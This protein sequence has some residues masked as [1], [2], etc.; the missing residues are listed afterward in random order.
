MIAGDYEL[1]CELQRPPSSRLTAS[2]PLN[3]YYRESEEGKQIMKSFR[4]NLTVQELI[5]GGSDA[6]WRLNRPPIY[7][8][9][10]GRHLTS[11]IW[12]DESGKVKS[13]VNV[14]LE[15]L[16]AANG[17][18]AQWTVHEITTWVDR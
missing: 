9:Q 8:I 6:K 4:E 1:A 14:G 15:Y 3:Q 12:E 11:T 10:S 18:V 16:P 2:M 5:D 17:N 13:L 7:S